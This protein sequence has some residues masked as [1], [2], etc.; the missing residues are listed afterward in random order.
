M[1]YGEKRDTERGK[2][3]GADEVLQRINRR[4]QR[5]LVPREGRVH[6]DEAV[7]DPEHQRALGAPN[8]ASIR[9]SNSLST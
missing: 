9:Y 5:K 1:G 7:T 4:L 8:I 2:R 6:Q 3:R